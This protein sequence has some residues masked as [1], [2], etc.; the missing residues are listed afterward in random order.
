MKTT[1]KLKRNL[2]AILLGALGCV[3]FAPLCQAYTPATPVITSQTSVPVV[4]PKVNNNPYANGQTP[5]CPTT[6][7]TVG[8]IA[9]QT[10]SCSV[11]GNAGV[12]AGL[13]LMTKLIGTFSASLAITSSLSS[14]AVVIWSSTTVIPMT[15]CSVFNYTWSGTSQQA[16]GY[17]KYGK[18]KTYEDD[19][20]IQ[21][22][23]QGTDNSPPFSA[24]AGSNCYNC[25]G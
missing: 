21:N 17:V 23:P 20:S 15:P 22:F 24:S 12:T 3:A 16:S 1:L 6:T 19:G 11:A 13:N 8:S 7:W 5:P 18:L 25:N 9:S 10:S 14:T 4:I 2:A